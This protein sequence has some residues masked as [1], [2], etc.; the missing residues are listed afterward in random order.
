MCGFIGLIAPEGRHVITEIYDG[1]ISI[2]HRGQDAAGAVTYSGRFN[3]KKGNGLVR[4]VFEEKHMKRLQGRLGIGHVRYPTVGDGSADDAQPFLVTSPFGI[5]L[6]HNGNL[7]NFAD[8]KTELTK[9][10]H[11]LVD[12]N[13][14][15]EAMLQVFAHSLAQVTMER[16]LSDDAV[17][18]AVGDVFERCLGAYST[19]MMIANYGLVAFRDPKGIKPIIFGERQEGFEKSYCVSSESVVLDLLDYH[20]TSNLLAGEAVIFKMDGTV[21]RRQIRHDPHHPC[22]FEWVYF[23]RPDS[24]LDKVSVYQT[25]MLLGERLAEVWR[26]TG[27]K[28]DVIIP[29]PES[30]RDAAIAMARCLGIKYREG[31]VKNRYIGRTFIMPDNHKRR[32]SIRHKLNAIQE[33]FEG[34]DV[35]LVDDSIVRGNTSRQIV[36]MARNAGSRK[37]Y[38]ASYSPPLRNPCVYGIDMSTRNEFV[39]K[40]RSEAEIA[41]EIGADAV[42]YQS[43]PDLEASVRANNPELKQFCNACFSGRYPTKEVTPELL[44]RIENEREL[45]HQGH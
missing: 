4:D 31:L 1:L 9:R 2:Q 11:R 41:R 23:A 35:L 36:R 7:T 19:V 12:S 30:A 17:F 22:L 28:A 16:D 29:V 13:C 8:L 39:A 42:I 44:R 26:K 32:A 14:D 33:E 34:K 37:V 3:V 21:A 10:D 18:Q 38:F 25:R 27:L 5:A 24:F 45:V 6:A 40:G 15:A 43:L 20:R